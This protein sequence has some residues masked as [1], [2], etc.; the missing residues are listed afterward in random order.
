MT[1]TFLFIS[2]KYPANRGR[3][4]LFTIAILSILFVSLNLQAP[5]QTPTKKKISIRDSL[6]R[7]FDLSDYIIEANGFV[8]VPYI[9]TEPALGG[10]GLAI[11]P[12]FIKRRP[13]YVDTINNN[14]VSSPVPPDITGGLAAYTLNNTWI[15]AAF[16][17]GTLVKSRI[18][19][20]IGG[21]YANVNM[22]FYH[23]YPQS[24]EQ[25]FNFNFRT[26]PIFL[27]AIRRIAYSR[28][29]IGLKYL[30]L[31]TE[32]NYSDSL[33]D[34][35][36]P[37]Q[38]NTVVSQ[39]GLVIELDTRDNVF[40]PDKGIKLQVDALGSNSWLGSDYSFERLNYY[41]YA[42]KPISPKLIGGWRLDG[43]QSFGNPPFYLLPYINM[44][45]IPSVRYQGKADILTELE[46]RW[47]FIRRWSLVF[48]GGTGKAFDYW[49]DFGSSQWI[50]S[51]GAGFR[52]LIARKFKLRMG[53]DIA[54][55]TGT[56]AYYVIFGS[57]WLK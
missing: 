44:R 19:Y 13:S 55:G 7:A 50:Y 18:K 52:Y 8:P 35:V 25:K 46:A 49:S 53:I 1:D 33:P 2:K 11:M 31:K 45:G 48:F 9:I 15:T 56:W 28:W 3:H 40:T 22:A 12:V 42:Y 24:G 23:N 57:S 41:L 29:H 54:H 38:M 21:G 39:L 10:F 16:R 14:V 27:Q 51:Y 32:V 47:D 6:D 36:K 43:Q 30:F 4:S 20:I 17:S 26:V 5:S 34:F 37:T